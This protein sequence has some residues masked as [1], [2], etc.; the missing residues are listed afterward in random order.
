MF[1][2]GSRGSGLAERVRPGVGYFAV[3]TG[4]PVL[5]VAVLGSARMVRTPRRPPVRIRIGQPIRFASAAGSPTSGSV[6]GPTSG[7]VGG[8]AG[9]SVGGLAGGSVGGPVNRQHWQA[10]AETVRLAL[11]ELVA[12]TRADLMAGAD[13]PPTTMKA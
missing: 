8:L 3:K 10:A 6:G 7:S 2:E 11:A 12:E 9:G 5:P 13:L 1:P 4:A